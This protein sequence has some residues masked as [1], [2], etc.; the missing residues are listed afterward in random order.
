MIDWRIC[1]NVPCAAEMGRLPASEFSLAPHRGVCDACIRESGIRKISTRCVDCSRTVK[2]SVG[3]TGL[4]RCAQCAPKD[5]R[6]P[7]RIAA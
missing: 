6:R 4:P 3:G 7:V 2:V 5:S 1:A